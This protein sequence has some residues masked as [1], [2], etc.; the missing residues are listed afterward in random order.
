M[1][2]VIRT[3]HVD[4]GRDAGVEQVLLVGGEAGVGDGPAQV[5]RVHV[6]AQAPV[7]RCLVYPD[8]PVVLERRCTEV[9]AAAQKTESQSRD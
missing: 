5:A 9:E 3:Y 4:G 6:F 1:H 7:I 2:R 8:A